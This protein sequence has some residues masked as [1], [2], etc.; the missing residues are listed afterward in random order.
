[1]SFDTK[2]TVMQTE[3]TKI[4]HVYV[5]FVSKFLILLLL[6]STCHANRDDSYVHTRSRVLQPFNHLDFPGTRF[7]WIEITVEIRVQLWLQCVAL[8]RLRWSF[9]HDRFERFDLISSQSV[10]QDKI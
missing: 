2:T 10:L 7:A 6:V 9:S 5:R 3:M 8:V 4:R 1:M